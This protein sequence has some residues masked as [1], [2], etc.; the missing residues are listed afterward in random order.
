LDDDMSLQ[1][2]IEAVK[3]SG[4]VR[5][6]QIDAKVRSES[7]AIMA[8]AQERA[9]KLLE[10]TRK[11]TTMPAIGDKARLLHQA[12]LE[13]SGILNQARQDLVNVALDEVAERLAN[14]RTDPA[15]PEIL[16]RL[17]EET[18]T[19]LWPSLHEGEIAS[20]LADPRDRKLVDS[21]LPKLEREVLVRYDITCWGGVIAESNDGRVVVTGT[22]EGR[23]NRSKPFLRQYLA[24]IIEEPE[25]DVAEDFALASSEA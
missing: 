23:F 10:E 6:Q 18:L 9:N 12:R 16:S 15:Y 2:I 4:E 11:S 21:I 5:V 14:A 22:L 17:I 19:E 8:D 13:A 7:E 24:K 1:G 25:H 20:L 3:A